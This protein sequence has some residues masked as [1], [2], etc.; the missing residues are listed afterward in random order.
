[1]ETERNI[2]L[3]LEAIKMNPKFH[4]QL[5]KDVAFDI[6]MKVYPEYDEAQRKTGRKDMSLEHLDEQPVSD[7]DYQTEEQGL[8][9]VDKLVELGNL[10]VIKQY[11]DEHKIS[12]YYPPDI[13]NYI[14]YTYNDMQKESY[15]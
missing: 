1:M 2:T 13:P 9:F 12:E 11:L 3:M 14:T 5:L 15:Q 6:M 8:A 7:I 4:Q 10:E